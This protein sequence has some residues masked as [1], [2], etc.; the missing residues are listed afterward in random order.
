MAR[1]LFTSDSRGSADHGWLKSRHT[2]SF[3][4]YYNPE[5]MGFGLLRVIND[6]VVAP[7]KGFSTHPHNDMEIISIPLSGSLR[8]QDSMGNKHIITAGEVQ[9]MS[10]GSGLTHSEYNNSNT[11]EVNFLQIWVLPRVIGIEPRYDQK[12]FSK[13]DRLNRLQLMVSPDGAED[14]ITINQ[15]AWFSMVD[16]TPDYSLTYRSHGK[17]T[18]IF[19]FVI[20][21]DISIDSDKLGRRDAMAISNESVI[22]LHAHKDSQVLCIEVPLSKP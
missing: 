9:I 4:S 18:G 22:N 2:F 5:R 13:I 21:G 7:S 16:L 10:A 14:S 6:D 19:V 1:E 15:S 17:N 8:H 20:D 12:A 11:E 3:S